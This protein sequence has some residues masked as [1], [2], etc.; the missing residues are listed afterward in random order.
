MSGAEHAARLPDRAY[1]LRAA[2]LL[3]F[4]LPFASGI[5]SGYTFSP[6]LSV[7]VLLLCAGLLAA[8]TLALTFCPQPAPTPHVQA[9]ASRFIT[10]LWA[11]LFISTAF[12][13]GAAYALLREPAAGPVL[14]VPREATLT[15]KIERL[16]AANRPDGYVSGIGKVIDAPS[17]L[18]GMSGQ[19]VSFSVWTHSDFHRDY[20]PLLN[21]SEIVIKGRLTDFNAPPLYRKDSSLRRTP[22]A[23]GLPAVTTKATVGNNARTS[24]LRHNGASL[25]VNSDTAPQAQPNSGSD[26][27]RNFLRS[28]GVHYGLDS[29]SIRDV[30]NAGTLWRQ[31]CE[32]IRARLHSA[33]RVGANTESTK[34]LANIGIAMLLG[35]TSVLPASDRSA[36]THSGTMHLFAVSGL[37]V[38]L[39]AAAFAAAGELCGFSRTRV[40]LVGILFLWMYVQVVGAPPS[41][42]RAWWMSS[43]FW[44]A[45]SL[46]R[47]HSPLSAL[48]ASMLV[49]LF[50]QP[51]DFLSVGFQL[52]YSV[53]VGILLYALP[54]AN[55]IENWTLR[56]LDHAH[57][58][59]QRYPKL[60][61]RLWYAIPE[62]R[63]RSL[64]SLFTISLVGTLYSAPLILGLFGNFAPGGLLIN[65]LLVPLA[66]W[67]LCALL[68]AC[69]LGLPGLVWV[70]S[71]FNH[72]AWLLLAFMGWV[73]S[74]TLISPFGFY[75]G[76]AGHATFR[77]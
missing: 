33:L 62:R 69:V 45:V 60:P 39:I 48:C 1:H 30:A 23:I 10:P 71:L 49:I 21:S 68:L 51:R 25:T 65:L 55:A 35:D 58:N 19:K 40:A 26:G 53:V 36:F 14:E 75:T 3:W 44:A 28:Q 6:W 2:P 41:A 16:F 54:L 17:Y 5:G 72:A 29:G 50:I 8:F 27:F 37:H 61:P 38:V 74:L 46:R 52:S 66:F 12:L 73:A 15:L 11:G 42:T 32:T 56:R 77:L 63:Q 67:V 18:P 7:P 22:T 34:R 47:Q 31:L 13:A 57:Y 43:L 59:L 20:P 64:L 9:R 24:D 70:A 76:L 4:A